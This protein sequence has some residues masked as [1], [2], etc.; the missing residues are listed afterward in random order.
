LSKEPITW[1]I[2][3][4]SSDVQY[5]SFSQD[6]RWLAISSVYELYL[7]DRKEP[8]KAPVSYTSLVARESISP[9]IF[10]PDSNWLAVGM[11]KGSALLANMDQ[12]TSD[13]IVL[14][15]HSD[16][17]DSLAFSPDSQ[18]LVTGS[19]DTTLRLWSMDTD[20]LL[21]RGC[22]LVGRNYTR[23]EWKKYFPGKEYP[24]NP[25]A[26]T[27]PQWTLAPLEAATSLD[28]FT[29]VPVDPPDVPI[30]IIPEEGLQQ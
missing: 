9:V 16:S 6:N 10:S 29:D 22:K 19:R 12:L 27:C 15:G 18:W 11:S 2:D 1:K 4:T 30:E 7:W 21:Q 8:A 20:Q 28:A 5:L 17:V 3:I 24:A 23:E 14:R 26:A 13:P 25:E